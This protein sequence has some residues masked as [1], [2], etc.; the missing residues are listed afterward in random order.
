MFKRVWNANFLK[1]VYFLIFKICLYYLEFLC[2]FRLKTVIFFNKNISTTVGEILKKNYI[3]SFF[4]YTKQ[5]KLNLTLLDFNVKY[6]AIFEE[7]SFSLMMAGK[8][9]L[10]K[11]KVFIIQSVF[12]RERLARQQQQLQIIEIYYRNSH[13][14]KNVFYWKFVFRNE[15]RFWLN[16]YLR[17]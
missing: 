16:K 15:N 3:K 6:W 17:I 5:F 7:L 9:H 1:T 11:W 8:R 13:S 12:M 2:I 4:K 14:V 10:W